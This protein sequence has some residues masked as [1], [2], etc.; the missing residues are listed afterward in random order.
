[1]SLKPIFR[2]GLALLLL[3][4]PAWGAE[5][6]LE[7]AQGCAVQESRL[8]RLNCYDALF[9]VAPE[10]PTAGDPRTPQW[11]A[12][13]ALEQGRGDD[14]TFRVKRENNG[15]VL[16]SAPALGTIAP[17]P[18]LVISCDDTITRFQLHVDRALDEGRTQL[19]LD[20]AGAA[21]EQSWRIRD[22]GYLVSGGRGLPAIDT[23][24]HLLASEALKLGS[25][26]PAL[27]GLRFD[28]S[29]LREKIQPLRK[30]CRW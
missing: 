10:A 18:R 1:M 16:M 7:Q 13:K 28:V 9:R 25:D 5:T 8:A 4:S 26:I 17:R 22:G 2:S 20:T 23:L 15:D 6:L 12:A 30:A 29:D 27:D 24:R 21:L 3:T 19:R 11:Y 14:F